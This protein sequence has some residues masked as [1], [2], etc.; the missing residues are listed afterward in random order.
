[1][2]MQ[3]V[4]DM[5]LMPNMERQSKIGIPVATI[6]AFAIAFVLIAGALGASFYTGGKL[7]AAEDDK[8]S[9]EATQQALA[10]QQQQLKGF[11]G[12]VAQGGSAQVDRLQSIM[13]S[14]L[15]YID[16]V[17][18]LNKDIPAGVTIASAFSLT[19]PSAPSGAAGAAPAAAPAAPAG[20]SAPTGSLF[21]WTCTAPSKAAMQRF[22]SNLRADKKWFT[23]VEL[24]SASRGTGAAVAPGVPTAP[25]APTGPEQPSLNPNEISFTLEVTWKAPP[26]AAAPTTP[27]APEGE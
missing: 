2:S 3:R 24:K 1:M 26:P 23:D 7:N 15:D 16:F 18:A 12:L 6:Q 21:T 5:S 25:V 8:S 27:T 9:A 17:R 19:N 20:G 14:R 22:I 11:Q 13:K 4:P 10:T